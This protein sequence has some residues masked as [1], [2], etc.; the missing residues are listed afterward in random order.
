MRT[1]IAISL[2]EK[3]I[4][5]MQQLA[6]EGESCSSS[7]GDGGNSAPTNSTSGVEKTTLPTGKK[8]IKRKELEANEEDAE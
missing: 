3:V 6:E 8:I 5:K 1:N 2:I 4:A 7:S